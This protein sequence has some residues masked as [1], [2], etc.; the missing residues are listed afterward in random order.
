M[1][2]ANRPGD[3]CA[4]Y[5]AGRG[6]DAIPKK[7]VETL[8]RDAMRSRD[9][10]EYA[11]CFPGRR[12]RAD[13]GPR[14]QRTGGYPDDV[15][16]ILRYSWTDRSGAEVGVEFEAVDGAGERLG[17][18]HTDR[19]GAPCGEPS[20]R[21]TLPGTGIGAAGFA[22]RWP[23]PGG[24][25][26]VCEGAIDALSVD[27]LGI[28]RPEDGI[29][30]AHGCE[31]L[32]KL[33]SWCSYSEILIYPHRHDADHIGERRADELA[34]AL[35]GRATVV[36]SGHNGRADLNDELCGRAPRRGEGPPASVTMTGEAFMELARRP[37]DAEL[38]ST[39]PGLAY[40]GRAVLIHSDRGVGKTTYAAWLVSEAT[41]AGLRVL[42]AVDDDPA[43]WA[44]R[45]DG[46]NAVLANL[47][48]AQ[49]GELAAP[50]ALEREA[51]GCGVVVIDSWRR[52]L[53]ASTRQSGKI[54]AAND[55]SVV[56]PVADRFVDVA[57]RGPGVIMLTNQAKGPDGTT[58]RGSVALEDA[59]DAVRTCVKVDGV[60]TIRTADKCR[61]GI[62]EGPWHM[63]LTE[64]GFTPS[65]G[66]RGGISVVDGEVVDHR[67]ERMDAAITG[68]LMDHP[69]G[70][71]M[72]RIEKSL[73]G[74]GPTIRARVKAVGFR[75]DDGLWRVRP[76]S[77]PYTVDERDEPR[78]DASSALRPIDGTNPDE[79]R[80]DASSRPTYRDEGTNPDE[81][82]PGG[83][84][85]DAGGRT[86]H[87]QTDR[88]QGD[89]EGGSMTEAATVEAAPVEDVEHVVNVEAAS[90]EA[91]TT[92]TASPT[93]RVNGHHAAPPSGAPAT[94]GGET[95][96]RDTGGGEDTPGR[97]AG[98]SWGADVDRW[99]VVAAPID[100]AALWYRDHP[101]RADN[102][103]EHVQVLSDT[104][105]A[106]LGA[107][108]RAAGRPGRARQMV[109]LRRLD[110][111][112][113]DGE[114]SRQGATLALMALA[115][116]DV[117]QTTPEPPHVA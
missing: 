105:A 60:T 33:A 93:T 78:P 52:W 30:A 79:P 45:L 47:R 12:Y 111:A 21:C 35:H 8:T 57:H 100:P 44:D 32:P 85:P 53:R 37:P 108:Y 109:Y 77:E 114:L 28:A 11:W 101:G 95:T 31:G 68:Y 69:E 17:Y 112:E 2:D 1:S 84:V 62:P 107:S 74:R 67:R 59:V 5:L 25:L 103:G 26:H 18:Q 96:S 66:G 46:F 55:E 86:D 40:R 61:V 13:G 72:N 50:G 113:L 29:V 6:I 41:R 56:G 104:P 91:D 110:P 54:G 49:M 80:P 3:P 58:A 90:V 81:P 22:V 117:A 83:F 16:G 71:S 14:R 98:D 36:R 39:A 34:A 106:A 102:R 89:P 87:D 20:K 116:D 94:G 63:R 65:D 97:P 115:A 48:V 99:A 82:R 27:P 73:H 75:G 9:P 42:M 38:V 70:S 23:K 7:C 64:A 19:D 51:D 24:R 88:G 10:H 43:S 92:S 4:V 15:V 76:D